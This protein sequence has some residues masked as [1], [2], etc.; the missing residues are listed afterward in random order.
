MAQLAN[1]FDRYDLAANGDDIREQLSDVISN[2]SPTDFPFMKMLGS[3]NT[4]DSDKA[5]W[6]EDSYEDPNTN[7][8]HVDGDEFEAEASNDT[9]RMSNYHQIS[10]KQLLVSRRAD[11][12]KKAGRKRELAYQLSKKGYELKRDMESILTGNQ[13]ALPGSDTVAPRTATL[14]AWLRTNTDRGA[15]GADPT[16]S[17]TTYGFPN[18]AATDGTVRALSETAILDTI[19][20]CYREGGKPEC[21][22]VGVETKRR[23]SNY[24]FGSDSRVATQYQD[25]GKNPSGGVTSVGAVDFYV[26]DYGKF[27]IM[28]NRFSR[29]RDV[30]IL[31]KERWDVSFIDKFLIEELDQ[32]G[33]AR[34]RHIISD[35]GLIC[36]S[37]N[38]SGVVADIDSTAAMV[39]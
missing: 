15:L 8:A 22:M 11:K 18:A 1:T 33:D 3:G 9:S 10:K 31:D 6:L 21:I 4:A 5:E 37:E 20:N 24:L 38:A 12:L 34:K 2:I 39:A 14:G 35:Y 23:I 17:S 26:S 30:W 7:N 16:L 19:Q 32:S 29:E 36:R 27:E 13:A 25:F 28:P